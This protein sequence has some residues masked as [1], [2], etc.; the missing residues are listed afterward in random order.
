LPEE[1]FT[2]PPKGTIDLHPSLLPKYRGAA[3]INWAIIKGEQ[4]TGIS[5]MF[6]EKQ[7][8]AGDL[9]LQRAMAIDPEET[10]GQLS[11][12]LA[13]LGADILL[14][15]VDDIARDAVQRHQQVGGLPS[16]APKL[17]REDGRIDW[18]KSAREV[19]DLI[20]G[21]NP[22]P[23]AFTTHGPKSI[24]IW[25]AQV[26]G[27]SVPEAR[28]G[29]VVQ[30]DEHHGILVNTADGLLQLIEVQLEGK[31]CLRAMEFL[32]GYHLHRGD[33]FD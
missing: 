32:R 16:P 20:R 31:R 1:I 11:Q 7:V 29:E 33:L 10:A 8:D 6:I 23:G 2:M 21:L 30:A 26:A 13:I 17:D 25:R 14:E 18:R 19:K 24:K 4:E 9:I 3:P 5:V 12:R 15:A 28:P 27:P 22:K